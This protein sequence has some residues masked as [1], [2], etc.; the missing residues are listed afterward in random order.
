MTTTSRRRL[1]MSRRA[2]L[3][4]GAS[5]LTATLALPALEAMFDTHGL[6]HAADGRPPPRRFGVFYWANG[7]R[8]DKWVP[9]GVGPDWTLSESLE[10]LAPVKPYLSVLSGLECKLRGTP[11]HVGRAAAIAGSYDQSMGS[12]GAA[13]TPSA[14]RLVSDAWRGTAPFESIQVGISMRRKS[15]LDARPATSGVSWD[16]SFKMARPDYAP[17]AL[18]QRLFQNVTAGA[19]DDPERARQLLRRRSIIDLVSADARALQARLGQHD[20]RRIDAH[21]EGLRSLERGLA[22]SSGG[23]CAPSRPAADPAV[24]LGREQLDERNKLMTDIIAMA[25]ACNLSRVVVV[26]YTCIQA[27]TIFWQVGAVDGNHV[28]THDDRGLPD[29]KPPQ[30]EL[31]GNIVRYVMGHFAQ[32]LTRLRD[33][34]EGAGNVLDSAAIVATSECGDGS[35]HGLTEF[36]MLIAGRAGGALK[37]GLHYRSPSQESISKAMLTALRAVDA[38]RFASFG[39]DAGLASEPIGALLV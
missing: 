29:K 16:A 33:M 30:K 5:G 9:S 13:T 35:S 4:G 1:V 18:Y 7:N 17:G 21:L 31:H 11:H 8:P 32:L 20:R 38:P 26:T 23:A 24:D 22:I 10:P 25:L 14:D 36:P 6:V 2:L 15:G 28:V 34:P 3:R 37:S 19:A 39:K 27:D 12:L